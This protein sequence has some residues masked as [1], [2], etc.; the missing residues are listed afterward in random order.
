ML[1]LVIH[2]CHGCLTA[3]LLKL[4]DQ[5]R[6]RRQL[7]LF[8]QLIPVDEKHIV[9]EAGVQMILHPKT[10]DVLE[11][12]VVDMGVYTKQAFEYDLDCCE[13]VLREHDSDLCGEEV[14]VVQLVLDPGH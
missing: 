4:L 9:L 2:H 6:K 11:V 3:T 1:T 5:F 13:E 12:G 8:H 7:F 14:L 10:H